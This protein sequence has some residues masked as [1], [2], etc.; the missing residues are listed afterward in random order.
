MCFLSIYHERPVDLEER[1]IDEKE[2]NVQVA[3]HL[4]RAG[5]RE[6]SITGG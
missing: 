4:R 1:I 2:S 3:E 5:G 6:E